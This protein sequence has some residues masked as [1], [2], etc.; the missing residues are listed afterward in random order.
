MATNPHITSPPPSYVSQADGDKIVVETHG[1]AHEVALQG[2]GFS[3]PSSSRTRTFE[4]SV[5]SDKDKADVFSKLRDAEIAFSR[6]REWCPAEVFEW[7]R[8]QGLTR[9]SF[10]S[11]AWRGPE[12]W[13]VRQEP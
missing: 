3:R 2:L 13:V 11:I 6:G 9:G 5:A 4:M 7:L 8:D 1:P 12:Q 10:Q